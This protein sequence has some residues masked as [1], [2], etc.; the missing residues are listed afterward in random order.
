MVSQNAPLSI[1][2]QPKTSLALYSTHSRLLNST[3]TMSSASWPARASV[4]SS[5]STANEAEEPQYQI[6][7]QDAR[8]KARSARAAGVSNHGRCLCSVRLLLDGLRAPSRR[9]YRA[10]SPTVVVE[11]LPA[12]C[13]E[14]ARSPVIVEAVP[15]RRSTTSMASSGISIITV[16]QTRSQRKISRSWR[17]ARACLLACSVPPA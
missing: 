10:E 1:A 4:T 5:R 8:E 3:S 16:E 15:K 12:A 6:G 14:I 11:S 7:G 13:V 9:A 17:R 2:Q